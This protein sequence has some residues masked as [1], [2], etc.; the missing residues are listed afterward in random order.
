[1]LIRKDLHDGYVKKVGYKKVCTITG[2]HWCGPKDTHSKMW[3]LPDSRRRRWQWPRARRK[4]LHWINFCVSRKTFFTIHM[5]YLPPNKIIIHF[6]KYRRPQEW[7][8]PAILLQE[9]VRHLTAPELHK[10]A[11]VT[12]QWPGSP[13]DKGESGNLETHGHLRAGGLA[14]M[15]WGKEI[16]LGCGR[17]GVQMGLSF[18]GM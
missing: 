6:L 3:R 7:L 10:L 14:N 9:W 18:L 11:G 4:H 12:S 15:K 1:M 2:W 17:T 13:W 5:N 16:W 8:F